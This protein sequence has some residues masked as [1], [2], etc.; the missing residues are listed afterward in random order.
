MDTE[1]RLIDSGP[2][3]AF[4]NMALD[5]AI[6]T[7]VRKGDV[8][9][10]LRLYGWDRPSL[11]LGCFQKT[12]DI[13]IVY[14]RAQDI[15]VVRR[16]TGGRAVLHGDE[17]TYSFSAKTDRGPFSHGLLDSY[18]RISEAFSIAL[19]K[20]GVTAESKRDRETG[21]VPD[22]SPLCFQSSSYG[23]LLL[24]NK[25]LVGS[26]QKRWDDG[27]LQQGSIPYRCHDEELKEI[28]GAEKTA[29]LKN[30]MKALRDALPLLDEEEFR[31]TVVSSFEEAFGVR[32][33][34]SGPSQAESLLAEELRERKYLQA[35]WNFRL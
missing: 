12:A 14:C 24:E 20:T 4:H 15:P 13:N 10:T 28:F 6:A 33:L 23:E 8:P 11:T 29:S 7:E 35:R 32:L 31:K 17:L 21:R 18:G 16:P 1:W 9:P 34:P 26:A 27:L 5:E 25:K 30:C 19:K 22:R 3:D 2:C